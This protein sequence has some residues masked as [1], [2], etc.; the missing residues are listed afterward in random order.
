MMDV[1]ASAGRR[2]FVCMALAGALAVWNVNPRPADAQVME[3][4]GV[5]CG[6]KDTQW[7]TEKRTTRSIF[8]VQLLGDGRFF[9]AGRSGIYRNG[10]WTR[11][12]P[13]S[14]EMTVNNRYIVYTLRFADNV[15]SGRW[16]NVK[17]HSGSIRVKKGGCVL[18]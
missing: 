11:N 7:S 6:S 18:R 12:G 8:I 4:A 1:L 13:N 16:R 2:W 3:V 5:W 9:Y 15:L 14:I 17:G 10:Y